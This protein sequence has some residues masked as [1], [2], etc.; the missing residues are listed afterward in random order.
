MDTQFWRRDYNESLVARW[1]L[2]YDEEVRKLID[3]W[4]HYME[5]TSKV[6]MVY[7]FVGIMELL[8]EGIPSKLRC[9]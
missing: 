2:R 4:V 1:L 6:I 8:L 7:P 9:G 5:V 3:D